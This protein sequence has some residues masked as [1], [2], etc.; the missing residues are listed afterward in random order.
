MHL[1]EVACGTEGLG[2]QGHLRHKTAVTA[3]LAVAASRA[4]HTVGAVHDDC[5]HE[6]QHV[7]NVA[8]IDHE[9]VIAHHVA[10]LCQPYILGTGLAGFLYRIFH[11]LATQELGF[12]DV[13][14]PPG[15]GSSHEQIG[16]TAEEGGYL[17]N[18]ADFADGRG[19]TTLV[20]IGQQ[21]Q[22]VL[23]LN[24]GQ[25]LES[26]LQPRATKRTDRGAVGLVERGLEDNVGS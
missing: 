13:D 20:N 2:S 12:L 6:F 1:E 26:A 17:D 8:E 19:L 9:V 3:R 7:G 15:L 11:V 10:A 22:T 18:I 24:V 21:A 5:R 25:H 4:L 16:L 23:C 14:R